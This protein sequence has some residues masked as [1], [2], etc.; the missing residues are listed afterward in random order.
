MKVYSP[1]DRFKLS[2]EGQGIAFILAPLTAKQKG[3]VLSLIANKGGNQVQDRWEMVRLALKY[4]VK[5]IDGF[6]DSE[7]KP[8]TLA[9]DAD[10]LMTDESVDILLNIG[11]GQ[12]V[13][14]AAAL[15]MAT[16]AKFDSVVDA[17]TGLPI[18]GVSF[19]HSGKV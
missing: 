6:T 3:D 12:G 18:D 16:G 1:K 11:E 5:G 17:E 10:G 13:A 4:S 15:Q 19:K 8:L 14:I 9:V 7:D 2:I